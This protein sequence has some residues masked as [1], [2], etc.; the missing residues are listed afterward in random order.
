LQDAVYDTTR[1]E[2]A[3]RRPFEE[4]V[5]RPYFHA[6]PLDGVQLYNWMK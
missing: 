5:R 6:K 2:L 4:A 3:R 1:E